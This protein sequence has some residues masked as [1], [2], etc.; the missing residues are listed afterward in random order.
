[1]KT[2]CRVSSKRLSRCA[3]ATRGAS[4]LVEAAPSLGGMVVRIPEAHVADDAPLSSTLMAQLEDAS[5]SH[6]VN[7][8]YR[9]TKGGGV[10]ARHCSP[11]RFVDR[12]QHLLARCHQSGRARRFRLDRIVHVTPAVG[13]P[14]QPLSEEEIQE[15]LAGAVDGFRAPEPRVSVRFRLV[16][17]LAEVAWML[18][19]LPEDLDVEEL[20]SG[21]LV[22]GDT[23][24]LEKRAAKLV[25][26]GAVVRYDDDGLCEA[27]R[28]VVAAAAVALA[29]DSVVADGEQ[30]ARSSGSA[31]R[32]GV[33]GRAVKRG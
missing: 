28:G 21:Y 4:T 5:D 10:E 15:A 12:Y 2:H 3:R 32:A 1:M 18:E 14:Y 23:G 33:H 17:D 22:H 6:A 9:N 31:T 27:A 26:Y 20:A 19:T 29:A 7:L 8:S 11:A 30:Q 25:T 24:A 16:G 13:V